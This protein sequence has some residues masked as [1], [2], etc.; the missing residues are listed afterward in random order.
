MFRAA[1]SV[2]LYALSAMLFGIGY[3]LAYS[4]LNGILANS[5]D[6]EIQPQALQIFTCSYFLGIYGFPAAAGFLLTR[7]GVSTLLAALVAIGSLEL[8]VGLYMAVRSGAFGR[9][10]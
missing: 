4:V 9:E 10:S 8:C 6:P 2:A 5:V 7:S 3:G 1:D